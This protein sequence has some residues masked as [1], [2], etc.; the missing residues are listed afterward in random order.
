MNGTYDVVVVGSGPNGL[1]AAIVAA[2]CGLSTVVLESSATAGGGTRSAELTLPGFVHDVCSAVHPMAQ[3]SPFFRHLPLAEYGL[4]WITPPGAAAHPIDEDEAALL[5]RSVDETAELL[6]IDRERYC[7]TIGCL[8]RNW[9][10]IEN[11]VLGPLRFPAHVVPFIAFGAV[12]L[13]P[14]SVL[15][16]LG[17]RSQRARAL[18]AGVAAHSVRPLSAPGSAAIGLVLSA[19]AH[20]YGWPIPR[21]GSQSIT[22]ALSRYLESLGGKII[23]GCRVE[24]YEQLPNARALLFDT[25]PRTLAKIMGERLPGAYRR[26]LERYP[27]GP[28]V[29]KVDWALREPIPWRAKE[30][31]RAAT[32][33]VGGTLDEVAESERAPW[34]GKV[35]ERPFVLVTQPSLFDNTRAP[36]GK[37]TAW[38]Y[39]HVP[40]GCEVNMTD[41]IEAQIERFAPG[42]REVILARAS[43]SPRVL[44]SENANLVGGDVA[45]GSNALGNLFL[46]PTWRTYSTPVK[47]VY[48]CS[49]STPPGGGVHGMCGY[50]TA[51]RAIRNEFGLDP[52]EWREPR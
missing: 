16:N 32:V 50:H 30:C 15:A 14:A 21:G 3:A 13:S 23:T 34:I 47:G 29:F 2:R 52:D 18:L 25:S 9:G 49:A 33:H 7:R 51:V 43:R 19:V 17:F 12:A 5:V 31:F 22:G 10:A 41:A 28:G 45:G 4:E 40:N 26:A 38:G 24:T 6:G 37:H 35:P 20:V 48:L 46:R 42:F 27:H 8:A 36:V 44:E 39:C 1:S 11:D